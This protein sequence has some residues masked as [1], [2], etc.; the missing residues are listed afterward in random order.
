[1][2]ET[3]LTKKILNLYNKN[4]KRKAS[5]QAIQAIESKIIFTSKE[6]L[7][8]VLEPFGYTIAHKLV[9]FGAIEDSK[10]LNLLLKDPELLKLTGENRFG[11]HA[12]GK[13][14]MGH[15]GVS[16]AFILAKK[17]YHIDNK[18]IWKLGSESLNKQKSVAHIMAQKGYDFKDKDILKLTDDIDLSVAHE[19]ARRGYKFKDKDILNMTSLHG[20]TVK[21]YQDQQQDQQA[22]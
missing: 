12:R 2:N 14:I 18:D 9:F 4:E 21:D 5:N 11:D 1:M 15:N 7:Q 22:A 10:F 6:V 17:G 3:T 16:I 8:Q 19:M 20:Y 13:N